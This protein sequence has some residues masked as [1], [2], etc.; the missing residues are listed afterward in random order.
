MEFHYPPMEVPPEPLEVWE[1]QWWYVVLKGSLGVFWGVGEGVTASL[2]Q[3]LL[4]VLLEGT[5]LSNASIGSVHPSFQPLTT[6]LT[7]PP[8]KLP[9]IVTA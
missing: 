1:H 4:V 3:L 8:K 9:I 7:K 6:A 2:H 5:E